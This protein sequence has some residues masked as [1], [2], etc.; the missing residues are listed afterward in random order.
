V[1]HVP[2]L[3]ANIGIGWKDLPGTNTLT[4]YEHFEITTVKKL[5]P[6]S[7]VYFPGAKQ[8]LGSKNAR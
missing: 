5:E 1:L 6:K 3:L 8:A 7:L 2:A 4:Y